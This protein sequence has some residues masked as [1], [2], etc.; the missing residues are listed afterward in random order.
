V[1]NRWYQRPAVWI[2]IIALVVSVATATL[3]AMS[4][5]ASLKLQEQTQ[6]TAQQARLTALIQQFSEMKEKIN[7]LSLQYGDKAPA[8]N[9]VE[10][11]Q[12]LIEDAVALLKEVPTIP[13]QK[14]VI[15][16]S[17]NENNQPDRA[18]HIA[19]KAESDA[20]EAKDP[21]NKML[22]ARV[23]AVAYFNQGK[24]EY[25][26]QAYA[27]ALDAVNFM[28]GVDR[29]I[30]AQYGLE[31]EQS[32]ISGELRANNC[33]GAKER[34]RNLEHYSKDFPRML[35]GEAERRVQPTRALIASTC[36]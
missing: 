5:S 4:S 6:L 34:L 26:R 9:G 29:F 15:A 10:L 2:S 3:T 7:E 13:F 36:D 35:A 33:S 16:E 27:R 24:I 19:R 8:S 12:P 18:E 21:I 32:W 22:A 14:M 25:G 23:L 31:I 28:S 20:S 30:R 1:R 17:L 11:R